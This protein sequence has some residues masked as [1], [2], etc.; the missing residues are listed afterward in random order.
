MALDIRRCDIETQSEDMKLIPIGIPHC[1]YSQEGI[2][3]VRQCLRWQPAEKQALLLV[4]Q[5]EAGFLCPGNRCQRE[6]DPLPEEHT[7]I[8]MTTRRHGR[9]AHC[10]P[11]SLLPACECGAFE[12]RRLWA[13]QR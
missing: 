13:L 2:I 6:H 4:W 5:C 9:Y 7:S 3:L 11:I 12:L 10:R 1:S 8:I